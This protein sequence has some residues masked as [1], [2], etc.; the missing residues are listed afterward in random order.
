MNSILYL[1]LIILGQFDLPAMIQARDMAEMWPRCG[2][3][4]A[5]M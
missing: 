3:D 1:I 4:V 2:R 5:E